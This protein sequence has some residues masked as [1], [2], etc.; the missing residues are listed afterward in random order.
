MMLDCRLED[1]GLLG[2]R[3]HGPMVK[4]GKN[5]IEYHLILQLHLLSTAYNETS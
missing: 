4:L 3:L 1:A 2:D 5:W